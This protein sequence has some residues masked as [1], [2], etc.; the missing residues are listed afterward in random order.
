M[1]PDGRSRPEPGIESL[2][3]AVLRQA[4]RDA[5]GPRG[6]D[7]AREW[8][9]SEDPGSAEFWALV[10]GIDPDYLRREVRRILFQPSGV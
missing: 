5:A 7:A 8:L 3:L 9:L 2:A 6:T 1:H 4:F 10:A